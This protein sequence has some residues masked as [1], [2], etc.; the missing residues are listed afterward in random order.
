M[1]G[2]IVEAFDR[3]D[4]D[5]DV[6]VVVLTG[7]GRAF[8][9]GADLSAGGSTFDHRRTGDA[10]RRAGGTLGGAP[11]DLGGVVV[12][13]IAA[14]TKP[15]IAAVNGP[16][17]G[18]GATMP[19][20][21]DIRIA[22]DTARF[23]YVFTRRGIA[24]DGASSWFLPR[25]VGI[26]QAMEWVATGRVLDA[27]EALRGRL[28]SRV[29]P[30]AELGATVSALAAEITENTSAVSVALSRRMLWAMLDTASPWEAHRT[31][32]R[33]ISALGREADAVEGV[34]S[35]LEK[36]PPRFTGRPADHLDLVPP[37]PEAPAD[38]DLSDG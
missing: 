7:A 33:V 3:A 38:L 37:W 6:R 1:A 9:A 34:K 13:R 14:S 29:V 8:C 30:A 26:S 32:T 12:L 28:V 16:A 11:R 24:P 27:D 10:R 35:F 19:L 4:A 25:I 20:A 2:E 17:V 15:V 21:A 31:E 5:D 22:S 36:R 18:V 23:G